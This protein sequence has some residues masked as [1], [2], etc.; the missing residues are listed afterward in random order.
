[1]FKYSPYKTLSADQRKNLMLIIDALLSE[2]KKSVLVEG[3]AG[4]GKTILAIFLFKLMLTSD[5]DFNYREF[6]EEEKEFIDKVKLLKIKFPNP[7]MG[8]VIAMGSFRKTIK[9][10]FRN[11]SG[12]NS[13]LVIG[14]SDLEYESYDIL[15]VDESHRLRKKS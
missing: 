12:L 15:F 1:M 10:V 11:I 3:G 5:E 7:K 8:L 13:N 9:K 6:G 2:N 4:T 14:P